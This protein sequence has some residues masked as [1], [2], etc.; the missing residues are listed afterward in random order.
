MK[1][2]VHGTRTRSRTIS[3]AGCATLAAGCALAA[4]SGCSS[5]GTAVTVAAD[6]VAAVRQAGSASGHIGTAAIATS[7]TM[8]ADGKTEQFSGTGSYD[9]TKQVGSIILTVPPDVSAHGTLDE[10]VTPSTLYMRPDGDTGKWVKVDSAKL[11]DGDLISAGYTSPALAFAML[12]GA[13]AAGGS[14]GYAGQ[15]TVYNVPVAHYTGTLNLAAAAA[16]AS[17]PVNTA[18]A[19]ASRSFSKQS[20]PFDVY[21]DAQGRVLRFIAHFEFPAPAPQKGE[22]SIVSS[23]D[24]YDI[25]KPVTA[26]APATADVLAGN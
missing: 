26:S 5:P 6:P 3:R 9:F 14:V 23:T 25:G 13:G 11:A 19:D 7:V 21:L 15:D 20:V 17:A 12:A 10:I 18:L 16:A 2:G 8:T 24:L 22:V 1:R 4:A